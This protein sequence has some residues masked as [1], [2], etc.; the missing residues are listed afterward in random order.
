M[1]YPQDIR[2]T[3]IFATALMFLYSFAW[4]AKAETSAWTGCL[5]PGGTIIHVA[6]GDAPLKRCSRN[7]R[8]IHLRDEAAYQ[9]TEANYDQAKICEAFH[10]L[11]LRRSYS[12]TWD[13]PLHQISLGRGLL[14]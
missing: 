1:Q 4:T 5:T 6:Q 14:F 10:A 9:H 11:L 13:A 12:P 3:G 8:L 7:Q 2:R